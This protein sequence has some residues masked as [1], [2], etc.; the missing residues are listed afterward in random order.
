MNKSKKLAFAAV[1]VV[2]AGAMVASI[3]GCK[4][5]S[6]SASYDVKLENGKLAYDANTTVYTA[7]GYNNAKTGI[8]YNSELI[9]SEDTSSSMVYAG[10]RYVSGD[11]KPAWQALSS[12][13]G[14]TIRD[15]WVA[16]GNTAAGEHITT[17][18]NAKNFGKYSLITASSTAI[19]DNTNKLLDLN[20][21]LDYMPN[22]KAFLESNDI[23]RL[24]IT[25][26]TNT[27][28]MYMIPYFDGYDDIEKYVLMRKDVVE[29]LLDAADVS[30]A[31]ETFKAHADTKNA[32]EQHGAVTIDGTKSSVKSFMGTT[33]HYEI[34]VTDPAALREATG[35][36]TTF[37]NNHNLSQVTKGQE[38]ATVTIHVDYDA[39]ISALQ[40]PTSALYTAV[41]AAIPDE[42]VKTTSGNIIDIQNQMIDDT[43]GLVT[44]AQLTKVLQE[45]I[46]VAY[47]K[48]GETTAFYTKLSD[49]FNSAYAAWDVDLYVALG[50]CLVTSG[51]VLGDS[52]KGLN[53]YLV[54]SR[55]GYTNRTYDIASMAGELYGVRG[56]TSRYSNLYAYIN[57]AGEIK[58]ARADADMW[59]ALEKMHYLALEGL[60]Y[61]GVAANDG[62]A[63]IANATSNKGIQFFSSTDYVQ[64]QTRLGGYAADGRLTTKTVEAGYNY[65][66]IL[67]PVSKWDVD[68]DGTHEKVMRFTE[69]WR[70][71]KDGGICIPKD[72]VK[73]DPNKL[74]AVLSI[75]DWMFSN[76]GQMVLTYGP[77]S[78]SGNI[79]EAQGG[80]ENADYGTWYAK[81]VTDVTWE[82][83]VTDKIVDTYDGVMY[84][85]TK[86]YENQYLCFGN[87]LYTATLYG[88]KQVPTPT[89]YVQAKLIGYNDGKFTDHARQYIG[90]ALNFGNKD[91]GFEAQC[92]PTCGLVGADIWSI[93]EVNGTI[94][95]T[96]PV[97][98]NDAEYGYWLTLV[99]T[100]L[101]FSNAQN[102]AMKTT[103]QKVTGSGSPGASAYYFYANSKASGNIL[104][105][106]MYYG[107][108]DSK[109]YTGVGGNMK[110]NVQGLIAD[111]NAA[112]LSTVDGYMSQA[113]NNIKA[114]YETLTAKK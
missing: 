21:Y 86:A 27:G 31:D 84:H 37:V 34:K 81:E 51:K 30:A 6:S 57:K 40:D 49:V 20:Q 59:N 76:D 61:T 89:D 50:R 71:V 39:V 106:V 24:S 58:D 66:P 33:S 102:S 98:V 2:M 114:Y 95:H 19:L 35:T 60:Y 45:Y 70:G 92:T 97:I 88:G 17:L 112:G 7:L 29:K 11:L 83:A 68:G 53:A 91:Q 55:T 9:K 74:S 72:A 87:K 82:K 93:A 22:Y 52:A 28:A 26:N 44:G 77:F 36:E 3:A 94:V 111:L 48:A 67:T 78:K 109:T 108:D 85:V 23:T 32:A 13:L 43:N 63:S 99:P 38:K 64:T 62:E 101:P 10:K 4:G 12:T 56:L 75:V 1:S 18:E 41:H 110:D 104:T 80:N 14:I 8:T 42:T 79:T 100:L 46:K 73:N 16:N 103:Y 96:E 113:W 54:G 69:S 107:Y 25:A 5:N 90:S 15:E 105:D 65:A 47:H